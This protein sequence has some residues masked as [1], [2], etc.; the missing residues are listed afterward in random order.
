M[1]WKGLMK[2]KTLRKD[3]IITRKMS[4]VL[5]KKMVTCFKR[6]KLEIYPNKSSNKRKRGG[7]VK[8]T[9]ML[10]I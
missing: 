6:R 1:R 9:T 7:K 10:A 8:K 3:L 5:L 2:L 4:F